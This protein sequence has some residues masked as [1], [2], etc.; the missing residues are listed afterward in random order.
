MRNFLVTLGISMTL[1][2]CGGAS[3]SRSSSQPT[4]ESEAIENL[5]RQVEEANPSAVSKWWPRI[6]EEVE[7]PLLADVKITTDFTAETIDDYVETLALCDA[8]TDSI[9]TD[10][11]WVEVYGIATIR[12][13]KIDGSV[14]ESSF[15]TKMAMTDDRRCVAYPYYKSIQSQMFKRKIPVVPHAELERPGEVTK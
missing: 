15:K 11:P 9:A 8:V 2:A 12:E 13:M 6:T 4:A 10:N 5:L 7:D 1:C 14:E 3:E